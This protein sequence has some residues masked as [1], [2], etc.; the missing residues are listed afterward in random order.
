ML[1]E[2]F[3]FI[4]RNFKF[5][6]CFLYAFFYFGTGNNFCITTVFPL[7]DHFKIARVALL[8]AK[9]TMLFK[10]VTYKI[11]PLKTNTVF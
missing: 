5:E 9:N 3:V 11:T 8:D 4:T 1:N 7:H 6:K 10:I 2:N